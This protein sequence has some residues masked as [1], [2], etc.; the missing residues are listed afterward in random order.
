[1]KAVTLNGKQA[2]I[3][4]HKLNDQGSWILFIKRLKRFLE[5]TYES[6]GKETGLSL[7]VSFFG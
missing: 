5:N 3:L 2:V 6:D 7:K 4:N 1:M